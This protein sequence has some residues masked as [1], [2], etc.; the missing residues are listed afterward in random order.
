MTWT[1]FSARTGPTRPG[2]AR[3]RLDELVGRPAGGG[4]GGAGEAELQ[5]HLRFPGQGQAVLDQGPDRRRLRAA[6]CTGSRTPTCWPRGAAAGAAPARR[7]ASRPGCHRGEQ[8]R[9]VAGRRRSAPLRAAAQA[10]ARSKSRCAQPPGGLA[11]GLAGNACAGTPSRAASAARPGPPA[12]LS[13]GPRIEVPPAAGRADDVGQPLVGEAAVDDA[14][15]APSASASCWSPASR[16]A[17][18]GPGANAPRCVCRCGSASSIG[19]SWRSSAASRPPLPGPAA[20][21]AAGPE[22]LDHRLVSQ[23]RTASRSPNSAAP[24]LISI[25]RPIGSSCSL[26]RGSR[27]AR[28]PTARP[29]TATAGCCAPTAPGPRWRSG[30]RPDRPGSR[31]P[32]WESCRSWV[33]PAR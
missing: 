1:R 8:D 31:T 16:P 19:R 2:N 14:S 33:F 32:R 11:G 7:A 24:Q 10:A 17:G 4:V 6:G 13:P 25:S 3:S 20:A 26:R 5:Q 22:Q 29:G 15:L 27:T 30:S 18:S 21:A 28:S 9:A 23:R 12:H